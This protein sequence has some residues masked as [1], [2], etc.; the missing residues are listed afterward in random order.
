MRF[1]ISLRRMGIDDALKEKGIQ[2]NDTVFING[3]IFEF[4]EI[5]D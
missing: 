4:T 1:A 2:E 3:Y 5:I